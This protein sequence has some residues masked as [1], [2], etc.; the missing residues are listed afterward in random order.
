[1][2]PVSALV[3]QLTGQTNLFA[4]EVERVSAGGQP[5][6]IRWGGRCLDV[7]DTGKMRTGARVTWLVASDYVVLVDP[8]NEGEANVVHGRLT[9][10]TRLGERTALSLRVDADGDAPLRFT[11]ATRD[12]RNHGFEVG[13]PLNVR[14]LPEGIHLMPSVR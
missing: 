8:A 1:L 10:V 12:A 3:A 14:L 2:R 6:R 11:M 4:G 13:R 7:A 9:D 5:G